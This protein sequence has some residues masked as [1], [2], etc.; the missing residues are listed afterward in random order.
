M[1]FAQVRYFL[2]LCREKNFSRAAK[3]CG[4]AQASLSKSIKALESK[5]GGALF[6]RGPKGAELTQLGQ[7]IEP[8]LAAIERCVQIVHKIPHHVSAVDHAIANAIAHR[9]ASSLHL[10]GNEKIL[11]GANKR[12]HWL[13]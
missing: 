1:K 12:R 11:C 6:I 8:Y 9:L 7:D 10:K 5:L 4:V 3:S 2:A 13:E